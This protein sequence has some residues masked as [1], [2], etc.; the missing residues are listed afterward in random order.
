[1]ATSPEPQDLK[2]TC[3]AERHRALGARMVPFAGWRMPVQ[4]RG[5]IEEHQHTRAQAGLFDICHMGE[6]FLRG[7]GAAAALERLVTCRIATLEDG[8]ARYGLM[9]NERGGA[10]D[11]LIM[12]RF[13]RDRF[14]V[15]VNAATRDK[16]R[17]WIEGH[18]P[19][20]GVVFKD[21]SDRTAKLDL[22]GPLS[23]EVMLELAGEEAVA[24]LRRFHLRTIRLGGIEAVISQ[25]GY[26]GE[27]GY[28]IFCD[29]AQGPE[30]WDA[31][32]KFPQVWPI[33]LGARDTLRLEKGLP[34]YGHEL[35]EEHTPLEAGLERFVSFEKE[36]I[37]REALLAQ[38]G[39]GVK[40]VLTGFI[41]EGRRAA[42]EG[43]E[44]R[45]DGRPVGRVTSGTFSPGL[46]RGI[47]MG[48]VEHAAAAEGRAITL[49]DG[50]TEIQGTIRRPPF[51]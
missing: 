8:Q 36:F 28:E 43:F 18:L 16:D 15:V 4:Y 40:R 42:R 46:T 19:P 1:M 44:I 35:D 7:E 25:T 21:E 39:E 24:G 45:A 47:G 49:T 38:R 10:L 12:F 22:Q 30:L 33:G 37:G 32:L 3:L 51:L 17:A 50:R 48:Y 2:E 11:D 14:M 5:I 29:I 26:T 23:R 9:L 20:S 34:L 41:C 6:F 31:L 13:D 27:L